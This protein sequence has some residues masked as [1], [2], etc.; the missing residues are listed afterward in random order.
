MCEK[1]H[2]GEVPVEEVPFGDSTSCG[3]CELGKC[4]LG[5]LLEKFNCWKYD[6]FPIL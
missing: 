1:C 4:Q 6:F 2:L 3:K 5:D